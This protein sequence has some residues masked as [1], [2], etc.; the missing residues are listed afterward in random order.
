MPNAFCSVLLSTRP[1]KKENELINETASSAEKVQYLC[2]GTTEGFFFVLKADRRDALFT[3]SVPGRISAV[4]YTPLAERLAIIT[5]EGHCEIIE[6]FPSWLSIGESYS[7]R[8]SLNAKSAS[9]G[10]R[11]TLPPIKRFRVASNC[12]CGGFIEERQDGQKGLWAEPSMNTMNGSG[13]SRSTVEPFASQCCGRI[14]LGSLDRYLYV[15]DIFQVS[16]EEVEGPP[17][18]VCKEEAREL[19]SCLLAL[20]THHPVT[21]VK[22]FFWMPTSPSTPI[23]DLGTENH[24]DHANAPSTGPALESTDK[25]LDEGLGPLPFLLLATQAHLILL[26]A[27]ASVHRRWTKA[28]RARGVPLILASPIVLLEY[29]S[30]AELHHPR[31]Q[32]HPRSKHSRGPSSADGTDKTP[33]STNH[34]RPILIPQF[35]AMSTPASQSSK[36]F[37]LKGKPKLKRFKRLPKH[38]SFFPTVKLQCQRLL[39]FYLRRT[40][41][42]V[43]LWMVHLSFIDSSTSGPLR[44]LPPISLAAVVDA[45]FGNT[46]ASSEGVFQSSPASAVVG[47]DKD[48]PASSSLP[49]LCSP[50][51]ISPT[52]SS[53]TA[54][55]Q[56]IEGLCA[57]S[58]YYY[59]A[60]PSMHSTSGSSQSDSASDGSFSMRSSSSDSAV[61]DPSQMPWPGVSASSTHL[62]CRMKNHRSHSE[63]CLADLVNYRHTRQEV[64][65][66]K[67]AGHQN[68]PAKPLAR[69]NE[70][71][72]YFAKVRDSTSSHL[73]DPSSRGMPSASSTSQH[74]DQSSRTWPRRHRVRLQVPQEGS[75][76]RSDTHRGKRDLPLPEFYNSADSSDS[77]FTIAPSHRETAQER[78]A[79]TNY[80][81]T[82]TL[83]R[84]GEVCEDLSPNSSSANSQVPISLYTHPYASPLRLPTVFIDVGVGSSGIEIAVAREDGYVMILHGELIFSTAANENMPRWQVTSDHRGDVPMVQVPSAPTREPREPLSSNRIIHQMLSLTEPYG[85]VLQPGGT[86]SS[87]LSWIAEAGANGTRSWWIQRE[88]GSSQAGD[89]WHSIADLAER[90]PRLRQQWDL[91]ASLHGYD[92][93]RTPAKITMKCTW[94]GC[95]GVPLVHRAYVMPFPSAAT[96]LSP[97]MSVGVAGNAA[98]SANLTTSAASLLFSSPSF[99]KP[100]EHENFMS[101]LMTID[102]KVY[103]IHGDSCSAMV[104]KVI[105]DCT[106]F[107]VSVSPQ[108]SVED[109]AGAQR[110]VRSGWFHNKPQLPSDAALDL[111]MNEGRV[112]TSLASEEP[113]LY[114]P[115]VLCSGISVE[116]VTMYAL[117]RAEKTLGYSRPQ[118]VKLEQDVSICVPETTS[119]CLLPPKAPQS[120]FI[121]DDGQE[122]SASSFPSISVASPSG[123]AFVT[124]EAELSPLLKLGNLLVRLAMEEKEGAQEGSALE[125]SS[126]SMQAAL[127]YRSLFAF[128]SP[129]TAQEVTPMERIW[130]AKQVILAYQPEE[131]ALLRELAGRA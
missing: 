71:P 34:F 68:E 12:V 127:S 42:V 64:K 48:F 80:S 131:W 76:P 13:G 33:F 44:V 16:P 73:L 54:Y 116:S 67:K 84:D 6:D 40:E 30:F 87:G 49:H 51:Y 118:H 104:C 60:A 96:S 113:S 8:T 97:S 5:L 24:V 107:A 28:A 4:F 99:S 117:G 38:K 22:F 122:S 108:P 9:S 11:A 46:F 79:A 32:Q 126:S 105:P 100:R 69:S 112:Q 35:S 47:N 90:S 58:S 2:V 31:S 114:N 94:G 15:Y 83:P 101:V 124:G 110:S 19:P 39:R 36:E 20:Y 56:K 37:P 74:S 1:F 106:T 21:S 102:G 77:F 121:D 26:P 120:L 10:D 130:V 66:R 7:P 119:V 65:M 61:E 18:A 123:G 91:S 75:G 27:E 92:A 115:S 93:E 63:S 25:P 78:P 52:S 57:S 82:S 98:L 72:S 29:L 17:S 43:P 128:A 95:L 14:A 3:H 81:P 53:S 125:A 129:R 86:V 85:R 89:A 109:K 50:P 70:R 88:G 103:I 62:S 111:A 41:L 55:R 45:A 23:S 59:H